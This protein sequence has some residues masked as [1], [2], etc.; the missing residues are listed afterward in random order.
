MNVRRA[1]RADID[2]LVDLMTEVQE[3]HVSNLA[4]LFRRAGRRATAAYFRELFGGDASR[5][6]LACEDDEAVGYLLLTL[7]DLPANAFM[8]A[9]RSLYIES[10]AVKEGH[11]NRGYGAALL[12]TARIVAREQGCEQIELDT[13]GFNE[14]AHAF[15]RAHGFDTLC[16][17]MA[18]PV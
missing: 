6:Y 11:R 7:L 1:T 3:L 15:F 4:W 12:E 5:I 13:W 8:Y 9:R 16:L 10:I 17:R 14:S 18:A 2:A